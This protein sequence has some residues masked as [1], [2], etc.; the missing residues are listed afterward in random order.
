MMVVEHCIHEDLIQ[1]QS[2][3]L[4]EL[5]ARADYKD[6]RI[7]EILDDNKRM[8]DKI[9][10]LTVAVKDLQFQSLKDDK[11]IDK[12]LT[13]LESTVN[14]IKWIITLVFGSG[15]IWIVLNYMQL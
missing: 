3:K 13:S 1:N 5:E 11:D 2:Q 12:R 6:K 10:H 14:T 4:A 7:D 8:E 9:D 15:I